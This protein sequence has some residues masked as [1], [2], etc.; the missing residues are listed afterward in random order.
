[1]TSV[2]VIGAG[3]AGLVSA[4]ELRAA[5]H[6]VVVFERSDEIGGVWVYDEAPGRTMYAS[7]RTNLPRDLMAFRSYPFDS[8]GG[9]ADDLPR[10]PSHESVLEYL[11]RYATDHDLVDLVRFGTEVTNVRPSG[12]GWVLETRGGVTAE[13]HDF[14][15]VAVC[16]GHFSIPRV[17]EI[18]GSAT[19]P[20]V[21]THSRDYRR[22]DPF[23]GMR[24]AVVGTGSSGLDLSLEL[25]ALAEHVYWCGRTSEDVRTFPRVENVSTVPMPQ[26]LTADGELVVAGEHFPVDSVILCTGFHYDL[27]FIEQGV[28]EGTDAPVSLYRH[29]V[30]IGHP[31][32]A[33]IG[34]PQRIIP[35]PL[36]EM[37]AKWFAASLSGV[38][39]PAGE[40][41]MSAWV[42]DW[43]QHCRAEGREPYQYRNIGA[44][45]FDYID[46][47][48]REC[49]AE[50][51]PDWYRPL[52]HE[53][54][55]SRLA[56][57]LEYRDLPLTNQ[58]DSR[59]AP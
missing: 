30:P 55:Q 17:I 2:A 44:E 57:L 29:L 22:P 16:N 36:F 5:G 9:G 59:L 20:G 7:L 38:V 25:A 56:N 1:M 21:L 19:F 8:S 4:K 49:G 33:L 32:M 47:L 14:D 42:E 27:S 12:G 34:I 40:E 35:F 51:L 37:Q 54:T 23:I 46:E 50:P 28:V 45:Q 13:H 6:D 10:F 41:Q 26:R 11:R 39:A 48:A 24:V 52:A 53:T 58:G 3:A 43:H 18:E 15:A 31:T